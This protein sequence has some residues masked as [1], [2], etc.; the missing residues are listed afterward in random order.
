M[1]S[2]NDCTVSSFCNSDNCDRKKGCVPRSGCTTTVPEYGY[3][4]YWRCGCES[5]VY[6]EYDEKNN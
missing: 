3:P 2:Y 5:F 6:L 4:Q 1:T